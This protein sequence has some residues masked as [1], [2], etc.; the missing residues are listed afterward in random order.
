M[1]DPLKPAKA[2]DFVR[3]LVII[4]S[5]ISWLYVLKIYFPTAHW[6][7]LPL[8]IAAIIIVIERMWGPQPK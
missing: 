3:L 6:L 5:N 2:N 1:Y 4:V 8:G 7:A